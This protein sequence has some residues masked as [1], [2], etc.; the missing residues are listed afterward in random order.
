MMQ[1]VRGIQPALSSTTVDGGAEVLSV[2]SLRERLATF[3]RTHVYREIELLGTRWRY[4]VSGQGGHTL[5]LPAG[6]TRV[7]DMYFLLF[8]ALEPDLRIIA[9]AYPP[10]PTMAGLVDGLAGIL[11]AEQ[12]ASVDMLGSSFGGSWRSASSASIPTACDG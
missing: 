5:L 10:I 11:D 12:V 9:P 4:M 6:G 3:R 1:D 2:A 8:E 7:P